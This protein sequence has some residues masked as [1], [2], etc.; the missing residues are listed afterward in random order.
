VRT[1]QTE[2]TAERNR[3]RHVLDPG[4]SR[5]EVSFA[6]PVASRRPHTAG[7]D[8][9]ADDDLGVGVRWLEAAQRRLRQTCGRIG[10]TVPSHLTLVI[11]EP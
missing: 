9:A 3:H 5:S 8:T 7:A 6:F 2:A 11:M 4:A 1:A 10:M